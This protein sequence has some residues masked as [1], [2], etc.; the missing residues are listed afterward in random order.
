M[1]TP[2][3]DEV[4]D[5]AFAMMTQAQEAG[6]KAATSVAE[7]W[8]ALLTGTGADQAGHGIVP[9]LPSDPAELVDRF[10]D[11]GVQVLEAQRSMAHSLLG[12]VTPALRAVTV[13]MPAAAAR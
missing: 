8:V 5:R 1:A 7:N 3:T 11:T 9:T 2:T 12:A 4:R 6:I 13:V 10:Y